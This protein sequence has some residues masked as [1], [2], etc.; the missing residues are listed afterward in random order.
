M[1]VRLLNFTDLTLDEKKMVLA[2]RNAES[3]RKWMF[4][5]EEITLENHLN[6]IDSLLNRQ[7]RRYFLVKQNDKAI[8]VI[9]F[10]NIHD[11]QADIGLYAKPNLRGVGNLLMQSIIDYGF[12]TLKV[13]RLISEV[14]ETNE[15]AVKLYT[16]FGFKR[17]G[18]RE[19]ILIMELHNENQ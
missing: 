16:K 2:W 17:I 15:A 4:T 7:D 10:T 8:G 18:Q 5:Q 11:N 3:I 9:D 12:K 13:N 19:T 6:Y 14:F 1:P